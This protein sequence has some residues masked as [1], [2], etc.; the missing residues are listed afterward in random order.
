MSI[1]LTETLGMTEKTNKR[2]PLTEEERVFFD[3]NGYLILK[4]VLPDDV[5]TLALEKVDDL[6]RKHKQKEPE[7]QSI[8]LFD[9]V[10]EED[11]FL[12]LLDWDKTITKVVNLLSS[13]IFLFHSHLDVNL[14]GEQPLPIEKLEW[15]RDSDIIEM[16]LNVLKTHMFSVKVSYWLS[17]VSKPNRGNLL[18]IPGSHKMERSSL[19]KADFEKAVPML[20]APGDAVFFDRRVWHARSPNISSVTRKALFYGYSF[21]WLA[22]RDIF[23][24]HKKTDNPVWNQ[25]LGCYEDPRSRYKPNLKDLPMGIWDVDR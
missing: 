24:R 25:L 21:R 16:D 1:N 11:F 9:F 5:V 6:W 2:Y 8:H 14:P 17:D 20:V 22:S 23:R 15:H 18:I 19:S 10:E 12:N 13:N 4:G 7:S 3:D